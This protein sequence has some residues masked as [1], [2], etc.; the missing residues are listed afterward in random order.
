MNPIQKSIFGDL[1]NIVI[2]LLIIVGGIISLYFEVQLNDYYRIFYDALANKNLLLTGVGLISL[3]YISF[4]IAIQNTIDGLLSEQLDLKLRADLSILLYK[5]AKLNKDRLMLRYSDQRIAE[6]IEIFT[7]RF[8]VIGLTFV[9]NIIKSIIFFLILWGMSPPY[10]AKIIGVPGGL[11]IA[12]IIYFL[13]PSYVSL[14]LGKKMIPL[15]NKKRRVEAR[16]R[17]LLID[18]LQKMDVLKFDQ[19]DKIIRQIK[20]VSQALIRVTFASGA[21]TSVLSNISF[22]IPIAIMMPPYFENSIELGDIVKAAGAFAIFQ[23]SATYLHYQFKECVRCI[24]AFMRIK[25][26]AQ[27]LH[28]IL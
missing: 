19:F 13:I 20:N 4:L 7:S 26:F 22:V 2:F 16:F 1:K 3:L 27:E 28:E 9:F 5:V 6:D 25:A 24:S 14:Y 12:T 15:E 18:E 17:Y 11:A 21:A 8:A 10:L 23:N